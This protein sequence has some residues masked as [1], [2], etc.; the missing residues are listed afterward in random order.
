MNVKESEKKAEFSQK[1]HPELPLTTNWSPYVAGIGLGITLLFSYL[2]LG[3]GLGASG[4]LARVSAWIEYKFAPERVLASE[5]F[6]AWFKEDSGPVLRYYLVFMSL[7]V[8][9][10]GFMSAFGHGRIHSKVE[11]G[12]KISV[13]GRLF[14]AFI[15]GILVGFSSRLAR[16]CTSGQA[17]SGSSMLFTGSFVFL[18]CMFLGAYLFA[19]VVRRA[20][21]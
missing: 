8:F 4:G 9:L 7:G 13:E 12:S 16:G 19:P 1:S 5:Y 17:L 6:G 14:L 10:G 18:G 2:I 11:R 21:K 20:W 15:G 3:T